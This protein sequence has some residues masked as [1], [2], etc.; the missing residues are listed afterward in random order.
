[1][2]IINL[3]LLITCALQVACT[4]NKEPQF[5]IE[6]SIQQ[7]LMPLQGLTT[8]LLV[9]IRHPYLI[10]QNWKQNDSLFHIYDLRTNELKSAFGQKG[11]GPDDYV[12][13]WL[14]RSQLKDFIISDNQAFQFFQINEDGSPILKT[15]ILPKYN[16]N[17][18]EG[19][20]INDSIFVVDAQYT[21]PY[22]Y[23]FNVDSDVPLKT[24][25]YRNGD[26]MDVLLDPNMGRVYAN[27]DRIIFSYEYKKEIDFMDT[28]FNLLKKVKFDFAKSDDAILGSGDENIAYGIGYCGKRYFYVI[29]MEQSWKTY[30]EKGMK[31][32][33]LEVFDMD[34]KPVARFP[35]EG[36]NPT[37]FAVDEETFTLYGTTEDGD[38]EDCLLVYKLNG[39]T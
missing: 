32:S 24:L 38:P 10:M 33:V 17:I 30:R 29:S 8:P 11:Q 5:P 18:N 23:T 39:L 20:F 6:S 21:G 1:M 16:N 7:E 25:K 13:P 26:I 4:S 28:D 12:L 27:E 31:G 14:I 36:K 15:R 9:E 37:Y 35:F 2:R 3:M 19:A 34:G 22:L